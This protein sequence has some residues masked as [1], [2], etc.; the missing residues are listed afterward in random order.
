MRFVAWRG[1]SDFYR[2][3]TDGHSPWTPD[4]KN[5]EPICMDELDTA[6][7]SDSLKAVIQSEGI[8]ALA[9]I[10]LI[11]HGKLMGKFMTYFNSPHIFSKGEVELS[12]TIARQLAFGVDRKRADENLRA[13]NE[14]LEQKVKEKTIEVRKLASDLTKAEQRDRHRIA[15]ILHDDLQQRLYAIQMQIPLLQHAL[16]ADETTGERDFAEINEQLNEVVAVMRHLSVDLSPP[17]LRDEGLTQAI[18]WLASQM[19]EQYDLHIELHAE[20]AFAVPDPDMQVLLYSS[21]RELLF[22]I[23]KHAGMNQAVVSL[24][25]INDELYIEVCDTGKGFNA[26]VLAQRTSPSSAGNEYRQPSFGLP[27]LRHR[28]SLFGGDMDIESQ[29][30]TGTRITLRIP[31][32]LK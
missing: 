20:E 25:R 16:E 27:T 11:S 3:A 22:N 1:L 28:L 17:I 21:V 31:V 12:L 8:G 18:K 5:P 14:T 26:A 29:P 2:K 19:Q 10:P 13:L 30:H 9:F 4:I 6:D 32:Y 15:Q 24:D 7:L 23:V